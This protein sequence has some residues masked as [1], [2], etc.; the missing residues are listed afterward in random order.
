MAG[1]KDGI[2]KRG[3]TWY[4]SV[5]VNGPDSFVGPKSKGV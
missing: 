3:N 5:K 2:W 1:V 4:I